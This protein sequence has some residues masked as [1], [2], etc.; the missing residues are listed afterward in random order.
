MVAIQRKNDHFSGNSDDRSETVNNIEAVD[1]ISNTNSL[2]LNNEFVVTVGD[3]VDCI[4]ETGHWSE[5][6]IRKLDRIHRRVFVSFA[7]WD[8]KWDC[9]IGN[10]DERIAP[11]QSHT[12]YKGGTLKIGQR[13]ECEDKK[14]DVMMAYIVDANPLEVKLNTC[15]CLLASA[16]EPFFFLFVRFL[17][18]STLIHLQWMNGL[19]EKVRA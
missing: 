15:F 4:D 10:V 5:A 2:I 17:F 8:S 14:K 1:E 18:T 13:I 11:L 3:R 7:F 9:W 6:V 12:Y 16:Q 19:V